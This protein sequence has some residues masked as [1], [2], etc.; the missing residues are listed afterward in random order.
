MISFRAVQDKELEAFLDFAK[1]QQSG[2]IFYEVLSL[3]F[4]R[5]TAL[6]WL[7]DPAIVLSRSH[8][9]G[10][11]SEFAKLVMVVARGSEV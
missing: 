6:P 5:W 8:F 11:H 1:D 7:A 9:A 2:N 10:L 3:L 4:C